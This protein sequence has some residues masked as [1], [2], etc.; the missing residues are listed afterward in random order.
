MLTQLVQILNLTR[1]NQR[2]RVRG[3]RRL[4]AAALIVEDHRVLCGEHREIA[5]HGLEVETRSAMN[6]DDRVRAAAHHAIVEPGRIRGDHVAALSN[7]H[8]W[9]EARGGETA[10]G[11]SDG[12]LN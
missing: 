4:S 2:R 1:G 9:N 5:G 6:G 8:S 3:Q 11:P 12:A 10:D 7:E